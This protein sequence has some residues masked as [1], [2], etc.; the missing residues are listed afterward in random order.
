M[1]KA[2][3]CL[4]FKVEFCSSVA[5]L[6]S[7]F[8]KTCWIL[9]SAGTYPQKPMAWTSVISTFGDLLRHHGPQMF[10]PHS[11][12]CGTHGVSQGT[13]A[14]DGQLIGCLSPAALLPPS[15]TCFLLSHG[16]TESAVLMCHCWLWSLFS[17]RRQDR[18]W[19]IVLAWFLDGRGL[20]WLY[21]CC[22]K[23]KIKADM[24]CLV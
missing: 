17:P 14:Q 1:R 16:R 5:G 6:G 24:F 18:G 10:L 7:G 22:Y 11:I 13:L 3:T 12:S 19:D 23:F 15:C 9:L 2:L 4:G 8:W 21:F 20:A